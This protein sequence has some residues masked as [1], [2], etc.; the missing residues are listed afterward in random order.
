MPKP[1]AALLGA[2]LDENSSYQRGAAEAP[3]AVRQALANSSTNLSTECGLDLAALRD[4]DEGWVD[5]GDCAPNFE[6][7]RNEVDT[8][9][10]RSLRP[11]VL[12]GDHSITLPT[13]RA[14][15]G[16]HGPL[17]ILHMDAHPDLY[18][19]LE[20]QR[21]SHACPFARACEEG[22]VGRLVQ[23]GVRTMNAHQLEQAT[24]FGVE[25]LPPGVWRPADLPVL[26]GPAYLSV[27]M[28][29]LDPAFAPGVSHP[30]PGGMSLRDLLRIIQGLPRSLVAADLVE[31]NPQL[32]PAGLTAR[33]TAKLTKEILA[34][35]I[36]ANHGPGRVAG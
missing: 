28:D 6:A 25:T 24:R 14:A 27:D 7:I 34:R 32:D 16:R 36:R 1:L 23:V 30:E 19:E 3:A 31:L 22:L 29:C 20:G 2:P 4:A 11:L 13:L 9:L 10:R 35:L 5:A 26:E 18:D 12:G 21:L 15:A 8:L 17:T 33:V